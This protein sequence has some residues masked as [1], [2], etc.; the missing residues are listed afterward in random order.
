MRTAHSSTR[1]SL[2]RRR[3]Q[4]WR[5]N[6]D[7]ASAV[8]FGLVATPFFLLIFGLIEICMVFII[9]TT[10]EHGVNEAARQIRTGEVQQ[11]GGDAA[12]FKTLVCGNL[13]NLID[14]GE[15]LYIDV[16]TYANFGAANPGLP[17]D[18]DGNVDTDAM[19]FNPGNA[20]EIVLVRAFYEWEIFTPLIGAPLANMDDD[21]RLLQAT[22]VFRNE[23]FGSGT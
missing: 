19:T 5:D 10:L 16:N 21:T 7:G 12:A 4:Q 8:E 20:D 2:W 6:R 11:D 14:C 17:L 18:V 15:K 1:P 23:P 13:F 22:A 3:L 9:S